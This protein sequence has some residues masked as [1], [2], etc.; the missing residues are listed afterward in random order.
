MELWENPDQI[1]KFRYDWHVGSQIRPWNYIKLNPADLV[2]VF[3]VVHYEYN[4]IVLYYWKDSV[5]WQHVFLQL[6]ILIGVW[7]ANVK[8]TLA[9][10]ATDEVKPIFIPHKFSTE[11][12]DELYQQMN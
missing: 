10:I 12:N 5:S 8:I 4:M 2:A 11:A 3:T 9:Y 1:Q 6:G 7:L